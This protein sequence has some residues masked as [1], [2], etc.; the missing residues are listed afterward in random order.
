LRAG[1]LMANAAKAGAAKRATERNVEY[2][3]VRVVC[4]SRGLTLKERKEEGER[5]RLQAGR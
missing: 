5:E 4:E 2:I 3:A 1:E